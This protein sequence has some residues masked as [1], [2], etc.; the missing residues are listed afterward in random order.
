MSLQV[1][2]PLKGNLEN[3]G[4]ANINVDVMGSIPF[5]AGKIGDAATF[6]DSSANCINFNGLEQKDNFSWTCWIKVVAG[7]THR[8]YILSEG[9]DCGYTGV[10]LWISN[11]LALYFRYGGNDNGVDRLLGTLESDVW[12]HVAIIVSSDGCKGYLNGTLVN[13]WG[14]VEPDYTQSQGKFVIG[15]M[16][17]NYTNTSNYHPFKGQINDVR[18]YDHCLSAKEVKL[19]SQALVCHYPL[20]DFVASPNL[21]PN[22]DIYSSEETAFEWTSSRTDGVDW[23]PH[24]AFEVKPSTT[25]TI[26]LC[27]DGSLSN[28]HGSAGM[29]PDQKPFSFWLYLCNNNTTKN[30]TTGYYDAAR[31]FT[32]ANNNY[33]KIGDRHVWTYTTTSTERYMSLRVNNYSDGTT[34]VTIKYWAFKVEEGSEPTPWIPHVSSPVYDSL[35]LPSNKNLLTLDDVIV[36]NDGYRAY[37]LPMSTNL[38]GGKTYTLQLW[39]V[40]VHHNA[41]DDNDIG[42]YVYWG[43]GSIYLFNWNVYDTGWTMPYLSHTFTVTNSQASHNDAANAWLDIY[44]SV[45]YVAGTMGMTIGKWKLEEGEVATGWNDG[46]SVSIV[47]DCSGYENNGT[48]AASGVSA[49]EGSIRYLSCV[50]FDKGSATSGYIDAGTGGKVT[51]EITVSTWMHM[52]TWTANQHPFSCTEGGGWNIENQ[53][54][55]PSFP[56]YVR[57]VGYKS[58]VKSGVTPKWTDLSSGWHLFTGTYDGYTVTLYIDGQPAG[59]NTTG[60]TSK[61]PI[62]YHTSNHIYLHSEATG[63][64]PSG[65]YDACK[66][67]D[68]RIYATALSAADVKELYETSAS[69]DNHGNMYAYEFNE[70]IV[71]DKYQDLCDV[72]ISKRYN[73]AGTFVIT[74]NEIVINGYVWLWHQVYQE[75]DIDKYDYYYEI[76]YSADA[77]NMFYIGWEKYDAN[78]TATANSSTVY[79]VNT[80]KTAKMHDVVSGNLPMSNLTG[81]PTK[82]V[83]L[84]I[85]NSWDGSTSS[86]LSATIHK[87]HLYAIPK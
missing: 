8:M 68:F 45:P 39:D 22:L 14:Y 55:M 51:D 41:K 33:R 62:Q 9:R 30:W 12:Y 46:D 44:N 21:V 87:L 61:L 18:I 31:N 81:N 13:T 7:A 49:G 11:A 77:G 29:T 47:H 59:S 79:I 54:S 65:S 16:S 60:S 32:S 58:S 1:W 56:V 69:V 70:G 72:V 3:L 66:M 63:S 40:S 17:Y 35:G 6:S 74:N 36:D 43:G 20:N 84:R 71:T 52:S 82:Y 76:E 25:Y 2:L 42:V 86:N 48:M 37:R 67:S 24:S 38:V 75:V 34:P 57:T 50:Q 10:S 27:S 4:L 64:G 23:I 5:S 26:S 15:K 19:I 83:M 85:L 28:V 78:K 53:S 73:N 80:N